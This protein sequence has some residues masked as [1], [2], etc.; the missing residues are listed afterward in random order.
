MPANLSGELIFGFDEAAS[1]LKNIG[2]AGASVVNL[3]FKRE[4]ISHA[5]DGIGAVVPAI[6][7]RQLGGRE[8]QPSEV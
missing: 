3:I 7:G 5:L 1:G 4:Q 6:E 8:F 2:Y